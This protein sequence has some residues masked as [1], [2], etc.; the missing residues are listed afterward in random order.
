MKKE[1]LIDAL[2]EIDEKYI[3]EA[4]E[5]KSF[6]Y[7]YRFIA[8]AAS[9]VLI[10]SSVLILGK[11]LPKEEEF[12]APIGNNSQIGNDSQLPPDIDDDEKYK[13][14]LAGIS[15][16]IDKTNSSFD[17]D[18]PED[19]VSPAPDAPG[20]GD[21]DESL[22]P[23]EGNGE[24]VEVTDNQVAGIIEGD[25]VKTTDKYIFR[26]GTKRIDNFT[27]A[28]TIRIYTIDG[29]NSKLMS[30]FVVEEF[31]DQYYDLNN[32]EMYLSADG[33]TVTVV[34]GYAPKSGNHRTGIISIDV[35]DVKNPVEKSR[36]SLD[37]TVRT[38]RMIDGKLYVVTNFY[39]SSYNI[40]IE[41]PE[42]FI[43]GI[44]VDGEEKL[45][46]ID[47]IIFTDEI[48]YVYYS[49]ITV[50]DESSLELLDEKAI[51]DAEGEAYFTQN[52]ILLVKNQPRRIYYAGQNTGYE[53]EYSSFITPVKFTDGKLE[54]KNQLIVDGYAESQYHFDEKDGYLRF[55]ATHYEYAGWYR[56]SENA[57]LYIYDLVNQ[58]MLT[59]VDRF[60]PDG[61]GAVSVRFEGN[62][63][64]VCTAVVETFSDPV[65]FFDLSDYSN[66]TYVDTGYIEGFSSSLIDMGEG[67]LLGV[68]YESSGLCKL[69]VYK[70]EGE[71]V[72]SVSKLEITGEMS[73]E[74]KSYLIDRE[75]NLFGLPIN[76]EVGKG[77]YFVV[78]IVDGKIQ[79][80]CT[81]E[82]NPNEQHLARAFYRDGYVYLTTYMDFYVERVNVK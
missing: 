16:Y 8:V 50:Y 5:K 7:K 56:K 34:R 36:V 75:N 18:V 1:K 61:E 26:Y 60:A 57:S 45:C 63:L 38:T 25:L 69:E 39:C 48:T 35:S 13:R 47:C 12:Y 80:L 49:Y 81:M 70:R 24:Y 55:V 74:Y 17:E 71:S 46:P 19:G 54:V 29:D 52:H 73:E 41:K 21:A 2:G 23:G 68:G 59:W 76:T 14:L 42:S 11:L 53:V 32:T 15:A 31:D 82:R 44:T 67:Y 6:I 10:I 77:R 79:V 78:Q 22:K 37:G 20:Y 3:A 33:K 58:E 27:H 62:K 30:E 66:I 40:D 9:L 4:T 51:M 72:V 65:F 43:P 64:Y 28:K